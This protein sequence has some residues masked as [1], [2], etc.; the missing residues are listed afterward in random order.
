MPVEGQTTTADI[1][2]LD[3]DAGAVED[4]RT[5]NDVEGQEND[6]DA[7]GSPAHVE[8]QTTPALRGPEGQ[9]GPGTAPPSVRFTQNTQAPYRPAPLTPTRI[10]T[11][12][13]RRAGSSRLGG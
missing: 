12:G 5:D 7:L 13:I 3:D 8:A 10:P 11:S 4:Q 1:L 9:P 2:R 6:A